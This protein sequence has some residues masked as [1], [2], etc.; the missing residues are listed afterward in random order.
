[1]G[2]FLDQKFI[3]SAKNY[4]SKQLFPPNH[5]SRSEM[6]KLSSLGI[7]YPTLRDHPLHSALT[8]LNGKRADDGAEGFWRIHD[9][10][11]DFTEFI[12]MHPGGKDWLKLTKGTDITEAF[13]SHHVSPAPQKMLARF[14]VAKARQP[15]NSPFTFEEDGFYRTLK[16]N[17]YEKLSTLPKNPVH[18]S[19]YITDCLFASYIVSA[20]LSVYLKSLLVGTVAGLM[21]SMAAIAAHNFFHQKDSFRMYY[22]DFTMMLSRDWRIS[23][24]LSHHLYTNT[25][26]DLEISFAEPFLRYLPTKKNFVVRY[27]SWV[28]SPVIFALLFPASFTK[29][30]L[31]MVFVGQ[32]FTWP[33]ILPLTVPVLM[34]LV[35]GESAAF[36]GTMFFWIITVGGLHFGLVGINAGHHHPDRF[37]DGDKAR[38]KEEQDWGIFQLDAVM[39]RK[40]IT[41]SHFLVLTNFGDHALHHLFP[42]VDHGLL[43]YLYPVF[44][45]TC[46]QFGTEWILSTQLETTK[47]QYR[48]LAKVEPKRSPPKPVGKGNKLE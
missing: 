15:R 7:K 27:L 45:E 3:Q 37:H 9:C 25:V 11:Y 41:G 23:H 30:L 16:K 6:N 29:T 14:F 35:T 22:F 31:Q 33:I 24:A 39:D 48:Q 1:M 44:L 2:S 36:C 34:L 32:E 13:E 10:L 8:W 47:G 18:R 5:K 46:K 4:L 19:K 17:V 28:Y 21:L 43:D 20:L 38:P 42:T 26:N 12:N 40:D